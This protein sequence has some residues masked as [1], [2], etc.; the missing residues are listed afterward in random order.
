[1]VESS[2]LFILKYVLASF[3]TYYYRMVLGS[4][5]TVGTRLKSNIPDE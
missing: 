1:M 5:Q 4:F 2:I 3:L